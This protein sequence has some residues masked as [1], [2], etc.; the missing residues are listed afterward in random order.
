MEACRC[1]QST[2]PCI[3][4][5][6]FGLLFR[7]LCLIGRC[8]DPDLQA[9]LKNRYR[10]AGLGV[11]NRGIRGG[12]ALKRGTPVALVGCRSEEHTSELQSPCNLV[13]RLLLEKKKNGI[14]Y[15][16]PCS[17]STLRHGV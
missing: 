15:L 4:S 11:A 8:Q 9:G 13:C 5:G 14:A 7:C 6:P 17:D 3:G 2:W 10:V 12:L 1:R 16:P